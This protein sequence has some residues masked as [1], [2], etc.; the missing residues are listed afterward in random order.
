MSELVIREIA[1]IVET[2]LG[3]PPGSITRDGRRR[4][5]VR[6]R[7]IAFALISEAFPGASDAHAAAALGRHRSLMF[8]YRESIDRDH[9]SGWPEWMRCKVRVDAY[10]R[11]YALAS[12]ATEWLRPT[13]GVNAEL[14]KM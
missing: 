11:H 10:L 2:E 3:Y 14:T 9:P 5:F 13:S 8:R 6:A 4:E 12:A 1:R 7:L